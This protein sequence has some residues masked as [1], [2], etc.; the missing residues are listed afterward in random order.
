MRTFLDQFLRYLDAERN[1]AEHTVTAYRIDLEH[2]LAFLESEGIGTEAGAID[3]MHIRSYLGF[4]SREGFKKKTMARRLS[5]IKSFF[6]YLQRGGEIDS[7]PARL[8]GTPKYEKTIPEFLTQPQMTALLDLMD[9]SR[10]EGVRDR[11]IVELFY[12]AGIRLNELIQLDLGDIRFSQRTISVVGKGSKQRII[13]V[14]ETAVKCLESYLDVR[15]QLV[16]EGVTADSKAVFIARNGK[17]LTPLA[18]QRMVRRVMMRVSDA[19]KLSPHVLRHTF[20]TH[21]LDNGADLRAVKDLL[22]HEYLST[23]QIYTHVTIERLK[24]VYHKAHPR[25]S[26]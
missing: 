15:T 11:A 13:P 9:T 20:A 4:L 8:V 26:E 5:S 19:S 23:T 1:Y 18:V 7:N 25:A 16:H 2:F 6:R 3:K 24:N 10:S 17:R 12:S 21:L 14:G 22:G